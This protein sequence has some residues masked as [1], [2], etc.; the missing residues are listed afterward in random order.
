VAR[1]LRS[2]WLSIAVGTALLLSGIGLA[3]ARAAS[4]PHLATI[5]PQ[6]LLA[7]VLRADG[8]NGPIS[9]SVTARIN[10]GFP[11]IP[12][13]F[14]GA[15]QGPLAILSYLSGT[16]RLRV[17]HSADGL[18]VADLLPVAE[19]SLF[20]SRTDAWAWDSA[21]FT[22]YHLGPFPASGHESPL[23]LVDP[24][25]LAR[26]SL[27]A[28]DPTTAVRLGTPLRIAGRDAYVLVL[29]PRTP[30]TLV[31]SIQI[32]IDAA[33]RVPLS[34]SVYPR[35]KGAPAISTAY[36]SVSFAT[37]D[38][39]IYRFVPPKD[40][41]VERPYVGTGT[42][43]PEPKSQLFAGFQAQPPRV[44]GAGWATIVAVRTPAMK[45]LLQASDQA[46]QIAALLPYSGPLFSARL[47][48]RG[49]HA[50]LVAGFVPQSALARL[51]PDLP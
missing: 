37:I 20:V 38:P 51:E 18:R 1:S 43:G 39:S 21:T 24:D 41:K 10:L 26:R 46:G 6:A 14:A 17:W 2:R 11:E 3:A 45:E 42:G 15:A 28:L 4:S 33:R 5:S 22:A 32:G 19:R 36:S 16:H 50:W 8:R 34:V 13:Q 29:T 9:G 47:V 44:F 49:D 35:G 27:E 23:G 12:D 7:T 25:A 30:E 48:D 40:A 31:G